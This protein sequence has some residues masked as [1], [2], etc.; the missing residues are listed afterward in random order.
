MLKPA[1]RPL[2]PSRLRH[3]LARGLAGLAGL[4]VLHVALPLLTLPYLTRVLGPEAWGEVAAAFALG[5]LAATL[6]EYGFSVSATRTLAQ[7]DRRAEGRS[8]FVSS[9]V[10]AKLVLAIGA[11]AVLLGLQ[12]VGATGVADGALLAGACLIA[13]GHGLWMAWYFEGIERVGKFFRSVLVARLLYVL[14]LLALIRT[15]ADAPLVPILYGMSGFVA[16]ALALRLMPRLGRIAWRDVADVLRAGWP[17]F[18]QRLLVMLY[19][20]GN[21]FWLSVL[22]GPV[23]AGGYGVAEQ[24][25]RA[26][27]LALV[28]VSRALYPRYSRHAAGAR[29]EG[30]MRYTLTA[31]AGAGLFLS[32]AVFALAGLLPVVFGEVFAGFVPVV[33]WL[34][35][36]PLLVAL[37][38]YWTVQRLLARGRD[39]QV[40]GLFGVGAVVDLGLAVLL[41]P[42]FGAVGM[43]MALLVA[44]AVVAVGSFVL[45]ARQPA[46]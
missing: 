38:Q 29:P 30:W 16:V 34:A 36:L 23:A 20:G 26:A 7:L 31:V 5:N 4:Q 33:R 1:P 27:C 18:A 12:A 37:S 19:A 46:A 15:P 45:A 32:A 8:G 2:L 25:V 17:G 3:P 43:A 44:E 14:F 11:V 35:P 21:V 13:A 22:A 41:V 28:P 6:P 42:R 39:T 9:V 24:S 10:A 40:A